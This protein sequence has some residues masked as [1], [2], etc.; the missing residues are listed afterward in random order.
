MNIFNRILVILLILFLLI[1][2]LGAILNKIIPLVNV[3]VVVNRFVDYYNSINRFVLLFFWVIFFFTCFILLI[4]EFTR[5]KPKVVKLI[6]IKE[7]K[8]TMTLSS[9]GKQIHNDV[10]SVSNIQSVR[11]K[12]LP[13][14]SGIITNLDLGVEHGLDLAEK[15]KEIAEVVKSSANRLGIKLYDTNINYIPISVPRIKKV[16]PEIKREKP[17]IKAEE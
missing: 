4:L 10:I 14:R 9:I 16:V 3:K 8:A 7:G 6:N 15:T 2:S 11:V 12:V 1:F 13:K 17:E 5:K